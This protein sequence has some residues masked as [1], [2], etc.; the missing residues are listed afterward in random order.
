MRY[1]DSLGLKRCRLGPVRYWDSLGLP[2]SAGAAARA[3]LRFVET[4]LI[5]GRWC[6]VRCWNSLGL[7]PKRRRWAPC[8]LGR[9]IF[10]ARVVQGAPDGRRLHNHALLLGHQTL[11]VKRSALRLHA[12]PFQ[13]GD[14]P[15]AQSRCHHAFAAALVVVIT[16]RT[17]FA[18]CQLT[19]S[20]PNHLPVRPLPFIVVHL[21]GDL[22][23]W[24][25]ENPPLF[26]K[27]FYLVFKL[28]PRGWTR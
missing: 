7:P 15:I 12:Q 21:L 23:P 3:M 4:A 25:F 6:P 18:F 20:S 24:P 26:M 17:A 14:Q 28:K 1:W 2:I 22:A 9:Q 5:R 10:V 11:Q 19:E 27:T 13:G 16:L 8:D